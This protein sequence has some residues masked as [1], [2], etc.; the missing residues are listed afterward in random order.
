MKSR[1]NM[2]S[3]GRWSRV[4]PR[5]QSRCR[6]KVLA[7][8]FSFSLVVAPMVAWGAPLP[9]AKVRTAVETW[10]RHVTAEARPDAAVERVEPYTENGVTWAY[11]LQLTNGG[12]CLAGADS[13]ALP[14]YL[15]CPKAVFD[16][17]NP[18]CRW[19]LKDIAARERFLQAARAR[20]DAVWQTNR[21]ELSR[22]ARFWDD[23]AAG[24]ATPSGGAQP[25][26]GP[27][28]Q[29]GSAGPTSMVLPVNTIWSQCAPWNDYCPTLPAGST[30][31]TVVGCVATAAVQV[32]YYWQWPNAGVNGGND[33]YKYSGT[34]KVSTQL[35]FDPSADDPDLVTGLTF[36]NVY[37]N[38]GD[39]GLIRY[40]APHLIMAGW[41]DG[42]TI[43]AAQQITNSSWSASHAVGY[44]QALAILINQLTNYQETVTADYSTP[45]DWSAMRN[46]YDPVDSGNNLII[47]ADTI[48]ANNAQQQAAYL[49]FE[50]G[51]AVHMGY[52]VQGSG[53]DDGNIPIALTNNFYYDPAAVDN[54]PP[55]TSQMV[56]DIQWFRPLV[57]GGGNSSGEGH[58]WLVYGYNTG[59][60]P[61]QFDMK[62]GWPE[63]WANGWYSLDNCQGFTNGQ[64]CVTCMAPLK[65][66]G[67][68]GASTPGTGSPAS[69]YQNI[70][71]ALP[72]IPSGG[73]L[74]FHANSVNTFS[75]STLTIDQPV[76]LKGYNATIEP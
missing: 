57:L 60:S 42:S 76:T 13:L 50:V 38:Y 61:W 46:T 24:T 32:M 7:R 58:A 3:R 75:G 22:R 14:V 67:F 56:A 55:N 29:G 2:Q 33:T 10:V 43:G 65:Q 1:S 74:V 9:Q 64:D 19:I 34:S 45:L 72:N 54:G 44:E 23:L 15:Y 18:D 52:G 17:K 70:Q 4:G 28:P 40:D 30:N 26:G 53:A 69:P 31:H 49:S 73:T 16:P 47:P 25:K 5:S 11:I 71:Q 62:F 8:W 59:T 39:S 48:P 51:V 66:V 63:V 12:F 36:G 20:G 35:S 41:W 37:G 27:V 68:V 21:A 6:F